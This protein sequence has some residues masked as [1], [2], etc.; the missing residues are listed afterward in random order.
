MVFF[1][2]SDSNIFKPLAAALYPSRVRTA[3]SAGVELGK[4]LTDIADRNPDMRVQFVGHSLGCRVVLSA[5][6]QLS[7]EQKVPVVRVLLMGAAVPESDCA[8][9]GPW[10]EKVSDLFGA[11]QGQE[12]SRNSDVILYSRDDEI[13]GKTFRTG[14][15]L[16][17]PHGPKLSGS[18]EAVGLKGGPPDRWTEN[19]ELCGL[20]HGDYVRKRRALRHVAALVGPLVVRQMEERP[21][22]E[23]SLGEQQLDQRRLASRGVSGKGQL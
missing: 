20:K 11:A 13:L 9:P 15:L 1:W 6:K 8:Q 5:V 2:P 3:I 4:Y 7:Q 21:E 23:R 19:V 14:E 10:P 16:V 17:R 12:V 18:R 22:G